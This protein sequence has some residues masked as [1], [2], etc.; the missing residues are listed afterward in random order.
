M[1]L[2]MYAAIHKMVTEKSI[3]EVIKDQRS[4]D[5]WKKACNVYHQKR[6]IDVERES[7]T[8]Y[9]GYGASSEADPLEP[10]EKHCIDERKLKA[11]MQDH[12]FIMPH[13]TGGLERACLL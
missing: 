12:E 4:V 13:F 8:Y 2:L 9:R 1:E 6:Q 5:L 11:A 10:R 3:D 7:G